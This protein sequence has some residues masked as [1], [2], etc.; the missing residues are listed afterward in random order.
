MSLGLLLLWGSDILQGHLWVV[1][2]QVCLLQT[3]GGGVSPSAFLLLLSTGAVASP[4]SV[5]TQ[6]TTLIISFFFPWPTSPSTPASW[7]LIILFQMVPVADLSEF[8]VGLAHKQTPAPCCAQG[9]LSQA[10]ILPS[11]FLLFPQSARQCFHD[12]VVCIPRDQDPGFDSP[13]PVS[14][15]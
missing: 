11:F 14:D 3:W 12:A 4:E 2:A 5:T 10:W 8:R 1:P 13:S 9:L 7:V 15:L 6:M